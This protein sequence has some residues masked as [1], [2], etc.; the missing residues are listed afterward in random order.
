MK[1]YDRPTRNITE[2]PS[3]SYHRN[4]SSNFIKIWKDNSWQFFIGKDGL[5][6]MT[7]AYWYKVYYNEYSNCP[8]KCD[9]FSLLHFCNFCRQLYMFR[10][11]TLI[12]WSSYNCNYSFWYWLTGSTTICSRWELMVV[13]AVIS[14]SWIRHLLGPRAELDPLKRSTLCSARNLTPIPRTSSIFR[15]YYAV[16]LW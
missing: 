1:T 16:Q 14:M 3:D 4:K 15:A 12:I 10:V 6:H 13:N 2:V 11:L 7:V 5:L 8:T 9:L